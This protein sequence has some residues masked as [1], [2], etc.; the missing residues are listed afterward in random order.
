MSEY[1]FKQHN[2][3]AWNA[4]AKQG[5]RFAQPARESDFEDPLRSV[6]G[7]RW[8]GPS[9]AG[10][11]VLCLAAGGGRQAPLYAAAGAITTVVDISDQMLEIDRQVCKRK[12]LTVQ[13]IEAS[14][15]DLSM[16]ADSTFD[17]VVHPVSTCY[18]PDIQRV[19]LEVSRLTKAGGLYISQHK[20]PVSLQSAIDP[21][22]REHYTIL[23]EYQRTDPLPE[24]SRANL[25]REPGTREYLH[26]WQ[27]LIGSMCR[28]G[29]VIEDFIE[30]KHADAS[31]VPGSFGHRSRFISPYVRIK[32]R[33][34]SA[35]VSTAPAI[36]TPPTS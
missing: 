16:L 22:D 27:S 13:T 23:H 17:I 29:F 26:D 30:P 14:M 21:N 5:N 3:G 2:R 9:I 11:Q 8:L 31:A 36:W 1:D 25:V 33:R 32:A 10:K 7:P 28:S 34:T 4:L 24:I 35:T 6:D 18:V 12:G 19:Y 20:Q 15:D